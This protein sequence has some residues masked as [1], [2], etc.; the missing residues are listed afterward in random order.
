MT[1]RGLA[2]VAGAFA[3][4]AV[5]R[6]LGIDEFLVLAVAAA[7]AV[8]AA[9]LAVLVAGSAIA[10]RRRTTAPRLPAGASSHVLIDL[11]NESLLPVPVLLGEDRCADVLLDGADVA[12][13][14]VPGLPRGAAVPAGY[15]ITGRLRGR[16]TVG[17]LSLRM[18]DPLGL[19]ERVRRYDAADEVVVY[20]AVEQL[21]GGVSLGRHQGS[22]TS[23]SRRLFNAG[24]E[25]HT[26]RE[27]ADGDDLRQV[28][29]RSTAHRQRI[30][31]RQNEL[32]WDTQAT[33]LCDTRAEAHHGS[34]RD[35][36]LERAVSAA[37][38]VVCHLDDH[39]YRVR[40]VTEA[41]AR[42]PAMASRDACLD[43]LAVLEA[44]RHRSLG[45]VLGQLRSGEAEGLLVAVLPAS[46]DGGG[47]LG[48]LLQV[49]RAFSGRV[50]IVLDTGAPG[51]Y[52]RA[53]RFSAMLQS[54][55]WRAAPLHPGVPLAAVW[56]DLMAGRRRRPRSP[57]S[58]PAAATSGIG[59]ADAQTATA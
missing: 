38:S 50:G 49:G 41:D 2:V 10:V 16:Y 17:P 21:P 28:H 40:L 1:R 42:V 47:D 39:G 44:T 6:L 14:V 24:D 32:P 5:G 51:C 9:V 54:A 45:P 22:G 48:T 7:A 46:E 53:D 58:A 29:W 12:R 33:I 25:F 23:L 56:G 11:R 13:F 26:M 19:V 55:G 37:A 4:W 15:R 36:S 30:M 43:R 59:P 34:G 57:V 27:Y 18:R 20:P 8:V 35:S 3:L 52:E 31:V